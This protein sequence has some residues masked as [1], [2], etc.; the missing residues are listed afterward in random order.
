MHVQLT[1]LPQLDLPVKTEPGSVGD[2]GRR[3]LADG[4]P[5]ARAFDVVL[6]E[7]V[8]ERCW[9]VV[10]AGFSPGGSWLRRSMPDRTAPD[11]TA[12]RSSRQDPCRGRGP[13]VKPPGSRSA[14]RPRPASPG[15][16]P[17]HPWSLHDCDPELIICYRV[18]S[19]GFQRGGVT[20]FPFAGQIV[21]SADMG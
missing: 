14:R 15:M 9:R 13:P 10:G 8:L 17:R 2:L 3:G 12:R 21:S 6:V 4:S 11:R 18:V 16:N 7:V 5:C 20:A 19:G 1:S